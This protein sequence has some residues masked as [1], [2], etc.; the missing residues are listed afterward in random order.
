MYTKEHY[1]KS[2]TA[3]RLNEWRNLQILRCV[4]SRMTFF[5]FV[6]KQSIRK[7]YS[8]IIFLDKKLMRWWKMMRRLFFFSQILRIIFNVPLVNNLS[9][10]HQNKITVLSLEYH[11]WNKTLANF[12]TNF[13]F[14]DKKYRLIYC[15]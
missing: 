15:R 1:L 6:N 9:C 12:D 10:H 11:R 8:V 13:Y 4:C 5:V 2:R 3:L 7:K 14:E